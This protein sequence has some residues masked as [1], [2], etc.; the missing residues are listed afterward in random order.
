MRGASHGGGRT[1][2]PIVR[3]LLMAAGAG[4]ALAGSS[5][6]SAVA[7]AC[8]NEQLRNGA[9]ASLPDCRAYE[10]VSPVDKGGVDAVTDQPPLFPAQ[11]APCAAGQQCAVAYLNAAAAFAGARGNELPNAYLA[12]RAAGEWLTTPL[13]PPTLEPP[14]NGSPMLS[15]A[16]SEDLSKSVVR[17]PFQRLTANAPAGVYNLFLRSGDGAYSLV[18]AAT[19]PVL[20]PPGCG[21]C[22]LSQ[23][24]P[25]FAG[26]S[27]DFGHVLFEANDSLVEGA[28]GGGV[29]NLYETVAEHV[30][31]VGI[32]PDGTVP[33]TGAT[34]GGGI[35]ALTL[36]ARQL[37]HAISAD[38]S[39]ILFQAQA[40]SGA[41]AP[42]QAGLV[43]LYDRID[44]SSTIEVSAPDVG[45]RPEACETRGGLCKAERARFWGASTDG[46][47]VVF[48]SKAS[49]TRA[50]FTGS[51]APGVENPGRDLYL[52]DLTSRSL[53]DIT[54]QK[55]GE[56]DP[57]G[58]GVL[59][60]VGVSHDG[61]YVYFV[62][63][64]RLAAGATS[65]Q[66]NLYV[67]H[68]D[69][70]GNGTVRFIATL[71]PPEEEE[72]FDAERE[73]FGTAFP[74]RSDI[75]D[76]AG[77]PNEAQAYVTPDGRHLAFMSA[78]SP[79]GYDNLDQSSGE[80]DHE[81]YL[82]DYEAGRLT[83]ASCD[84]NGARPL[85]SAFLGAELTE[86]TSTPFHQPRSLSDDGSRL[87][88]SSP[89]P[90]VGGIAGG[91]VKIFEFERGSIQPISPTDGPGDDV[92]LDASA[93]G[94]DV[95]FASR[96]RLAPGDEDELVD[97]YDA[98]VGGGVPTTTTGAS[99][100]ASGECEAAFSSSISTPASASFSGPGNLAAPATAHRPTARQLLAHA[101]AKC[102]RLRDRR[103]RE[104]CIRSVRRRFH[105]RRSARHLAHGVMGGRTAARPPR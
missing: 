96:D 105:I 65:G 9:S 15:Y 46:S 38:G 25:A 51:E 99:A 94:E 88:F 64:G 103:R 16:F 81:V 80:S 43:E 75:L 5:A 37:E 66:P 42:Q 30:R 50:S 3:R 48:T 84:P 86:R 77:R 44:G 18:T 97:V 71:S 34:A 33:A 26:A 70:E 89:D 17:V 58:A 76:W 45:A 102:R 28:P 52:Y 59:G 13:A 39:R 47:V 23:D 6:G 63:D 91:P 100:C 35:D 56:E 40:D 78:A 79:T 69:A 31:L 53:V 20:P 10:Q 95:F 73:R 7:G 87:F 60:V 90:L 36:H 72:E 2:G 14:P 22:F 68:G 57:H 74:Y 83:C 19:P 98:R 62:A 41:P 92:F 101:L 4:L 29:Q 93:S 32:L 61:S 27:E 67:W 12:A 104:A 21:G 54:V 1:A 82:Y 24:V 55:S 85:G 49:L 8:P 11:A